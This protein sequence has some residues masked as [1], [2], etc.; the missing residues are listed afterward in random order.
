MSVAEYE[1][2][3]VFYLG[4]NVD[5]GAPYLYESNHLTTHA[6]VIGM[7]GSG[8]TG[9]SI[10]L[11]EEAALDG[12]PAIV[13]DPK[14]DM[15]NLLLRFPDL[16]AADF[17]PWVPEGID[18]TAEAAKWSAGLAAS[19]QDG[20]RIRSLSREHYGTS[21]KEIESELRGLWQASAKTSARSSLGSRRRGAA[22]DG[23]SS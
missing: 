19:D 3:G 9:L 8:K 23:D 1:K 20:E 15:G 14:G 16:A 21:T 2:L 4:R 11:L 5:T 10:G 6:V 13:V 22:T 12:L 17:A 18:P 7:T